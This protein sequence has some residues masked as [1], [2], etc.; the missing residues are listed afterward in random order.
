M[1]KIN[2]ILIAVSV[3]IIVLGFILMTG[4]TNE[5]EYN[6]DIFSPRRI[7]VA[8]YVCVTGFFMVIVGIMYKSKE[9]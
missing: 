6:S 2:Y 9:K 1:K 5:L 7:T 4:S 8:P 3:A